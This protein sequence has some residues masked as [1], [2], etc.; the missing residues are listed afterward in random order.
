MLIYTGVTTI[1]FSFYSISSLMT[2]YYDSE[3]TSSAAGSSPT[4]GESHTAILWFIVKSWNSKR[5][6][7]FFSEGGDWWHS[8]L[9]PASITLVMFPISIKWIW[10][11]AEGYCWQGR[12]TA[13]AP[14]AG[15]QHSP[16]SLPLMFLHQDKV[17]MLIQL[18]WRLC[19]N[20]FLRERWATASESIINP[21]C[22]VLTQGSGQN[23]DLERPLCLEW[24][25]GNSC[26]SR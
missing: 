16:V 12:D 6:F 22:S 21:L 19:Q 3:Q 7:F 14:R 18:E 20:P 2:F 9:I 25:M 26:W 10:F 8:Y 4:S 15:G 13:A 17:A 11:P 24:E 1:Y 23:V 5:V